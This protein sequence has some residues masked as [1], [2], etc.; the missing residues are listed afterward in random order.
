MASTPTPYNHISQT[1]APMTASRTATITRETSETQI[2]L[3]LAI[4]GSGQAD[5]KSGVP[6]LDHMLT[7]FA[8]HGFLT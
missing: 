8:V 5:I 6:F 7:L 4:D 1:G 2:N 3:E